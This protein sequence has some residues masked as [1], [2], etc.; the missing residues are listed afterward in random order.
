MITDCCKKEPFRVRRRLKGWHFQGKAS[1]SGR[2]L[3]HKQ[4]HGARGR[5]A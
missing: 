1:R 4:E 2:S 3:Q 5:G